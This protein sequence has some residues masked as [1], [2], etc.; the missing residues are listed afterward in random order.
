MAAKETTGRAGAKTGHPDGREILEERAQGCR[1][2]LTEYMW[3]VDEETGSPRE[4]RVET[5]E[6]NG[7]LR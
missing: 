4:E 1:T 5:V 7:L 6:R 3:A 2:P